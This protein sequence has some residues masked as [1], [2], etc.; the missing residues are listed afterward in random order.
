M[1]EN[2]S[3]VLPV[4]S[5]FDSLINN[6]LECRTYFLHPS[7]KYLRSSKITSHNNI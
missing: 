3:H 1:R 7:G 6:V 5:Q 2:S 4:D